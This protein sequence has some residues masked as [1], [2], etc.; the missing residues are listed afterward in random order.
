MELF[1][2]S[3]TLTLIDNAVKQAQNYCQDSRLLTDALG[4]SVGKLIQQM[5]S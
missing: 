3:K 4:T 2:Y 5:R 1:R